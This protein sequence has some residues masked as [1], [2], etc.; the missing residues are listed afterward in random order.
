MKLIINKSD[1]ILFLET[2]DENIKKHI[3]LALEDAFKVLLDTHNEGKGISI[4]NISS[5]NKIGLS[6]YKAFSEHNKNHDFYN[7]AWLKKLYSFKTKTRSRGK[8]GITTFTNSI[9]F[10]S[11]IHN[12]GDGFA[13]VC[14][15]EIKACTA[16][17]SLLFY[18]LHNRGI[19]LLPYN[20]RR[21]EIRPSDGLRVEIGHSVMSE[22]LRV[23]RQPFINEDL[24]VRNI[25]ENIPIKSRKNF[26]WKAWIIFQMTNLNNISDLTN[27]NIL[28]LASFITEAKNDTSIPFNMSGASL[29]PIINAIFV[30]YNDLINFDVHGTL[31]SGTN[32]NDTSTERFLEYDINIPQI[33]SWLFFEE[34]FLTY[35]LKKNESIRT[36]E[37]ALNFLNIY[38]FK[39]LTLLEGG[40]K[41]IP[42]PKDFNRKYIDGINFPSLLDEFNHQSGATKSKNIN[43]LEF[44]FNMIESISSSYEASI[45]FI[46]PITK[47]DTPLVPRRI[48]TNKET[49]PTSYFV[50][51]YD[52]VFSICEFYWYLIENHLETMND[53]NQSSNKVFNTEEL[54]FVPVIFIDDRVIPIK[55]IPHRLHGANIIT[56][57]NNKTVSIPNFFGL[58]EIAISFETG[59]RHIHIRW[60][61]RNNYDLNMPKERNQSF[62]R[63]HVN[64]DKCNPNPWFAIVSEK[65]VTLLDRLYEYGE[66]IDIEPIATDYKDNENSKKYE[67]IT[68]LFTPFTLKSCTIQSVDGEFKYSCL[69]SPQS[70]VYF[71]DC[72]KR[73]LFFF[74]YF[75]LK[76]TKKEPLGIVSSEILDIEDDIPEKHI[77]NYFNTYETEFTPHGTRATVC[78]E[79]I[80]FL[81]SWIIMRDITGHK[82]KAAFAHYVKIDDEK[83]RNMTEEQAYVIFMNLHKQPS[84]SSEH[85]NDNISNLQSNHPCNIRAE[86]V[87]SALNQAIIK[88]KQSALTDFGAVGFYKSQNNDVCGISIAISSN[89]K[90]TIHSTHICPFNDTCPDD[91]IKDKLY[92]KCAICYYSIKTVDHLPRILSKIRELYDDLKSIDNLILKLKQRKDSKN[93]LIEDQDNIRSDITRDIAA[94]VYTS[95]MLKIKLTELQDQNKFLVGKPDILIGKFQE[96]NLPTNEASSFILRLMDADNYC[97]YQTDKFMAQLTTLKRRILIKLGRFEE[98]LNEQNDN[99]SIDD[100]RGIFK[101]L[102]LTSGLSVKQV[103]SKLISP[104]SEIKLL[105]SGFV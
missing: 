88:N 12:Y 48:G 22:T 61:D 30:T 92:K 36:D 11:L 31:L 29:T 57:I 16:G 60:L 10:N 44:L 14:A 9:S 68:S 67:K 71:K 87:N 75:L 86:L 62:Y 25:I 32:K 64:T 59:I 65:V 58:F 95:E 76:N 46:N 83:I 7:A 37:N 4:S 15:T 74:D 2:N 78:S 24:G 20:H 91:V 40:I 21:P 42:Y 8:N 34:M 80:M 97:E 23:V 3:H 52:F 73:V 100:F 6:F 81:P 102:C 50:L 51:V 105:P 55:Y 17:I 5:K 96:L 72:Y 38:L 13:G 99:L 53:S 70:D 98:V 45:G 47:Y 54:G 90:M 43:I 27:E 103:Y 56:R 85:K 94:W 39:T 79:S 18:A 77:F 104:L 26:D 69:A 63:L 84:D 1:T 82:S 93:S 19:L 33:K 49:F 28:E 89:V 35:R 101:S 41:N 66:L